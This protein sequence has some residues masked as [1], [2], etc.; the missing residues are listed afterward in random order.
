MNTETLI[1]NVVIKKEKVLTYKEK[2]EIID[3]ILKIQENLPKFDDFEITALGL[4]TLTDVNLVIVLYDTL[5]LDA[6]RFFNDV[7]NNSL[8]L[9][10]TQ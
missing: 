3:Q 2:I 5:F 7:E 8:Y 9:Q 1:N 10:Q 6:V 4:Q